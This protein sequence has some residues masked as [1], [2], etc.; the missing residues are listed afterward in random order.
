VVGKN[1]VMGA[2]GWGG[3]AR[4]WLLAAAVVVGLVVMHAELGSLGSG[5]AHAMTST[6]ASTVMPTGEQSATNTVRMHPSPDPAPVHD[7]SHMGP[8]CQ[9]PLPTGLGV[10]GALALLLLLACAAVGATPLSPA[11]AWLHR[12]R[13]R[14]RPPLRGPNLSLLCVLRV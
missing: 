1:G 9:A 14:W 4:A 2:E 3:K 13:R 7:M 5:S 6:M 8:I 10:A 11:R 12:R